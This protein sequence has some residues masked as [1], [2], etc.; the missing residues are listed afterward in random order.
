[1]VGQDV[2]VNT[3]SP[4]VLLSHNTSD[5]AEMCFLT[6]LEPG[7]FKIKVPAASALERVTLL[8]RWCLGSVSS[9]GRKWRGKW[10]YLLLSSTGIKDSCMRAESL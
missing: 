9:Y 1:M 8:P 6:V 2:H 3:I 10:A 4:F 7:K 5:R